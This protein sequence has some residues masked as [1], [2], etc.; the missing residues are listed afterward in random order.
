MEKS[1]YTLPVWICFCGPTKTIRFLCKGLPIP[2]FVN[3]IVRGGNFLSTEE[4]ILLHRLHHQFHLPG[5][6]SNRPRSI[7]SVHPFASIR[8]IIPTLLTHITFNNTRNQST[9]KAPFNYLSC[10]IPLQTIQAFQINHI[11]Y[12]TKNNPKKKETHVGTHRNSFER[13]CDHTSE[14]KKLRWNVP[15]IPEPPGQRTFYNRLRCIIGRPHWKKKTLTPLG[16]STPPPN[17]RGNGKRGL[18]WPLI[19]MTSDTHFKRGIYNGALLA[20]LARCQKIRPYRSS[21]INRIFSLA[22]LQQRPRLHFVV[23]WH[24]RV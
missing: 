9:C 8:D 14:T 24:F 11:H 3:G 13:T 6:N 5:S 18:H 16:S 12:H 10:T 1:T 19:L 7:L 21:K 15:E 17:E 22:T 20:D 23:K 2:L 4:R